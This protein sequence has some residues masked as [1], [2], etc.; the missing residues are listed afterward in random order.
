MDVRVVGEVVAECVDGENDTSAAIGEGGL[1]AQPVLQGVG[2]EVA[3]LGEAVGVFPEDIAQDTWEGEYPVTVGDGEADFVPNEGGCIEGA[4]L[5][6]AGA[7]ASPLTSKWE[8]V[9]VSAVGAVYSKEAVGE[10]PAAKAVVKGGL[11]GSIKW[12]EIFETLG[13]IF[14]SEGIE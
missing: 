6:A 8:Q 12:P 7:A 2:D 9:V 13:V 11:A 14:G 4:S 10:V 1:L 5:M 3:K